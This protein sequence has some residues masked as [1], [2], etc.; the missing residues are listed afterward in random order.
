MNSF[1]SVGID[2]VKYLEGQG[3][4]PVFRNFPSCRNPM[5]LV[6]DPTISDGCFWRCHW[7]V[8]SPHKKTRVCRRKVSVRDLTWWSGS[9]LS[10]LE[11]IELAYN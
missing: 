2:M 6:T 7:K 4:L 11:V 8:H 1:V 9:H 3:W 5:K 10:M